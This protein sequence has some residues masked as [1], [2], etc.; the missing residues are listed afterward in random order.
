MT[1]IHGWGGYPTIEGTQLSP[2]SPGEIPALCKDLVCVARGSGR[3]YGDSANAT[4]VIQS[5]YLNH[6][7]SFDRDAGILVCEAGVTIQDILKLVVPHGWFLPVT[8]GTSFVTVGGAIASDVHG[9]NHH[10]V[11]SFCE[12]VESF[13]IVL[14]SGDIVVASPKSNH[15]LYYATC[16]GMGLTGIVVTATIRL[17]KVPSPDI[18]QTTIKVKCLEAALDEFE[19]HSG[20]PYTVAWTDCLATGKSLGKSTV[21]LGEHADRQKHEN[22]GPLVSPNAIPV[23]VYFPEWVMSRWSIRAFNWAY[24]ATHRHG[25]RSRTSFWPYFY[26]LDR[27]SHLYRLYGRSGFVQYQFVVPKEGGRKN[28]GLLLSRIANSGLGTPLVVLKLFGKGNQNLLSFPIEGYNLALDFTLRK[29]TLPLL[30]VLDEIVADVGGR[31]YLTKDAR[32]SAS[33]FKRTYPNWESFEAVREK[34]GAIG[35]FGS[36]QSKRLGLQ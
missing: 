2:S 32:M 20:S 18:I 3:S 30:D 22:V 33:V 23:P 31:V 15:D 12:H 5:T 21:F 34:F 8:P 1:R 13:S 28:L 9:K 27:L 26:P 29:E 7:I 24:S 16:G 10:I 35:R 36:A 25:K 17:M 19:M 6:F 14:G 11:G 4:F